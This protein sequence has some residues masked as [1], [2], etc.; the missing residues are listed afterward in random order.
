[1]KNF[2]VKMFLLGC[3]MGGLILAGYSV[4]QSPNSSNEP[5]VETVEY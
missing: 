1:M 4:F 5:M 2:D 3:L